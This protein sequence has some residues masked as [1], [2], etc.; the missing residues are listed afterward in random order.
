VVARRAVEHAGFGQ[1][2]G[3]GARCRNPPI[4][5]QSLLHESDQAGCRRFDLGG[6]AD[7]QRIEVRIVERLCRDAHA[8][9][10]ANGS[11]ILGQQMHVID[12]LA[13][14]HIREFEDGD[15]S[16]AHGLK[17]RRNGEANALHGDSHNVLKRCLYDI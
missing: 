3:A 10:C 13:D 16:E 17:A 2:E 12:W 11:A 5:P 15:H 1:N 7:N 6:A 4:S 9:R 8:H 14:L